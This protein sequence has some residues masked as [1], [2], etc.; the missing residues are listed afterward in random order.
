MNINEQLLD[1]LKK[2]RGSLAGFKFI[3]GEGNAWEQRDE[4][5]L[6]DAE[7]AIAAA[8]QAQHSK[9]VTLEQL[10]DNLKAEKDGDAIG[11]AM[12]RA[13]ADMALGRAMRSAKRAEPR[14]ACGDSFTSDAMCA[15]CI[16]AAEQAPRW[17]QVDM[18]FGKFAVGSSTCAVTGA[19]GLIYL[20]LPEPREFNADCAD[21]FPMGAAAPERSIASVIHFHSAKALQQTLDVLLAIQRKHYPVA[22]QA[23]QA[24]PVAWCWQFPDG[25]FYEVPHHDQEDCERDCAGYDGQPV[26]LYAAQPVPRDVLMALAEEVLAACEKEV[27]PIYFVSLDTIVD[28][29]AAQPPAVA[30]SGCKF[31]LCQNEQY[32]KDMAEA[33]HRELYAGQPAVAG[34]NA[35]KSLLSRWLAYGKAMQ[36]AGSE[37]PRHLIAETEQAIAAAQKG[38]AA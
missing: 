27:G 8:E 33:I 14:C 12:D 22:E 6:A 5:A 30:D 4:D 9:T 36:K 18:G 7:E 29:Y 11:S 10:V 16:S 31:P 19:P 20:H 2:A 26:P 25:A 3:P 1:A 28:R 34:P 32:Q 38:G 37:L 23:Q 21:L 13:A 17:P 24:E 35:N 15:N